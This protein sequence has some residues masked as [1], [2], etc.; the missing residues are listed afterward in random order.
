MTHSVSNTGTTLKSRLALIQGH[1]KMAPIDRPYTIYC[2]SAIVTI[3][4]FCTIFK[5]FDVES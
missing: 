5:L 2:W 1:R 3:A 4:L